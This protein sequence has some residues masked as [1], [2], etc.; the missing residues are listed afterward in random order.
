VWRRSASVP[1]HL[2][3]TI[4]TSRSALEGER[5]QVTVLLADVKGSMDLGE[6]IVS[7][8]GRRLMAAALKLR[9]VAYPS[10]Y[11]DAA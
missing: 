10:L 1:K 11:A 3:D 9:E 4:L 5:K 6:K 7:L 8:S 2:A